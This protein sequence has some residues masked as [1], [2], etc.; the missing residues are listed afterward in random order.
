V[1][2]RAVNAVVFDFGGVL[3]DWDPR[4]LYRQLF[5]DPDEMAHFL[6]TICNTPWHLQHDLGVDT[7]ESCELLAR[8]HPAYASQIMAWSERGEEMLAGQIDGTVQLLTELKAAGL[9][10]F[11]L[12]NMEPDRYVARR[13]RFAFMTW[14]DGSVIS[15]QEGVIKPDRKIFEILLDRYALDPSRTVFI[16]DNPGNIAAAADLGMIALHFTDPRQLRLDLRALGLP[17]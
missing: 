2:G 11:A 9:P 12:S 6:A 10:L 17:V 5:D 13:E 7:R 15:G 14:F 3:L 16:D 8:E 1:P 4:Y